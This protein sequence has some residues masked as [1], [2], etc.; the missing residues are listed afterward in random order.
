MATS[1]SYDWTTTR[2]EII[3]SAFRKIGAMGDYETITD[4]AATNRLNAGIAAINPM[5]KAFV[6]DGMQLWLRTET[7]IPLS[8][9]TTI[10]IAIGPGQTISNTSKLTKMTEAIRRDSINATLPIDVPMNMYTWNEYEALSNKIQTGTPLHIHYQPLAYSGNLYVWPLP[11][12]YW[13]TNGSLVCT[14]HRLIQ[15]F[16]SATDEP[17]FPVEWHEALIYGLAVRLAP[18]YGLAMQDRQMLK[19]EAR[20][21]LELAKNFGTEE[22][23][24][25]LQA[26][27][28]WWQK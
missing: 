3:Q 7:I 28:F 15:D 21:A 9:F 4:P 14:F 24:L 19:Q 18:E 16:D 23:S 11:D 5:I 13:T 20:D 12:T 26:N 8:V 6:A 22:G 27:T 25:F 1:G 10:P 17:D 2:N